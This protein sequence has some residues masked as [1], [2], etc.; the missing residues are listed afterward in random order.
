MLNVLR[1]WIHRFLS[2][3]EA[4]LFAL[5]LIAMFVLLLTMGN[6]LAP[7]LASIVLAFLMQGFIALLVARNVPEK[8]AVLM[9]FVLFLGGFVSLLVFVIPLV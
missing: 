7:V 2:D 9:T 8:L 5:L 4:V 6:T 1:T 3:E